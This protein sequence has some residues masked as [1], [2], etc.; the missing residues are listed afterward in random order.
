[1]TEKKDRSGIQV[2]A[3]ASEILRALRDAESGLSLGKIAEQ[4]N[5]PRSTVQ[6]IT[7]ALAEENFVIT[8]AKGGGLRLGPGL[9]AL[10]SGTRYDVV[11]HCRLLL[12]EVTQKTGETTDLAVLRGNGMVFI[13]Q[14]PGTRRLT[15]VS[16]TGEVF[17]LTST[18][19]G[20]ACLAALP[21]QDALEVVKNEWSRNKI[22]GDLAEFEKELDEIAEGT[23]AY[24]LDEHSQGVS[25]I[26][27][28]FRDWGGEL[29]AISVPIPTSRFDAQKPT[30][31]AALRIAQKELKTKF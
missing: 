4:V 5:L 11:E 27:F 16:Q 13:D 23:F 2:I 12:V 9:F 7:G 20:K 1:M 14:V 10:A 31:E 18:A 26:G 25:A 8:D 29:H 24:D 28:A 30:V 15:T 6:R 17:P 3:R 22:D 19:N 21:R